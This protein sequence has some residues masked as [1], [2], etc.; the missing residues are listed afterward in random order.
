[1]RPSQEQI[2]QQL[3][4]E[5]DFKSQERADTRF[6]PEMYR[7]HSFSPPTTASTSRHES[8]R[9]DSLPPSIRGST[10]FSRR[11]R[12]TQEQKYQEV[13]QFKH[14]NDV[15]SKE[16]ADTRFKSEMYRNHSFPP[17][18][19]ASTSRNDSF[20]RSA[21]TEVYR[22]DSFP[23]SIRSSTPFRRRTRTM[24][25]HYQKQE[26]TERVNMIESWR[27]LRPQLIQ[28]EIDEMIL[29]GIS[30]EGGRNSL[31]EDTTVETNSIIVME[32][33]DH[34][35]QNSTEVMES[36]NQL[37][38]NP[39]GLIE[40]VDLIP[41]HIASTWENERN[42]NKFASLDRIMDNYNYIEDD[43]KSSIVRRNLSEEDFNHNSINHRHEIEVHQ[44]DGEFDDRPKNH[45]MMFAKEYSEPHDDII[46]EYQGQL[47]HKEGYINPHGIHE[48]HK[49]PYVTDSVGLDN[50]Q[51][52][53]TG[54]ERNLLLDD[55][56]L[57]MDPASTYT[58]NYGLQGAKRQYEAKNNSFEGITMEENRKYQSAYSQQ[59]GHMEYAGGMN[60]I[61]D[62][63]NLSDMNFPST[64]NERQQYEQQYN[65]LN[66]EQNY[67][68]Q[69]EEG[70]KYHPPNDNERVIA[71]SQQ[72]NKSK[73][74]Y[75]VDPVSQQ[76]VHKGLEYLPHNA[77][78]K[79]VASP[80]Q[81]NVHEF[82]YQTFLPLKEVT[83]PEYGI[84]PSKV[85][86]THLPQND[87]EKAVGS[88]YQN[89]IHKFNYQ[90]ALRLK[91]V[92][93]PDTHTGANQLTTMSKNPKPGPLF[94]LV[95]IIKEKI[96][97]PKGEVGSDKIK[98]ENDATVDDI[99]QHPKHA[100]LSN[101]VDVVKDKPCALEKERGSVRNIHVHNSQTTDLHIHQNDG[102]KKKTPMKKKKKTLMKKKKATHPNAT[103]I[104]TYSSTEESFEKTTSCTTE[105]SLTYYSSNASIT[106]YSTEKESSRSESESTFS[107][108]SESE[109]TTSS[110]SESESTSSSR[111]E[112]E[113]TFT[114]RSETESTSSSKSETESI[115]F[116]E[117]RSHH[118][119][120]RD[121]RSEKGHKRR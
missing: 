109:S 1:M 63:R 119:K 6:K 92:A 47:A 21:T 98:N 2:N 96:F 106:Y 102:Q 67:A 55:Q 14:E 89:N 16:R 83:R 27:S 66:N 28:N 59:G 50:E 48:Y 105:N 80:P 104:S 74:E 45:H 68:Q 79:A 62:T 90:T 43:S 87:P 81:K 97:A 61:R 15:I 25:S 36:R 44:S 76:F 10:P 7:N 32:S 120:H 84:I 46:S 112:S 23:R 11:L 5:N 53:Y 3:K 72:D 111:F 117:S 82:N 78:E 13:K 113:G 58:N 91:E 12:P 57:G 73:F 26:D 64:H 39:T 35:S 24:P 40:S 30:S 9:N 49:N 37:L 88:P 86:H 103:R 108:K 60:S 95:D 34:I 51:R 8:Y 33:M 85:I 18:P 121:T 31:Q 114:S 77:P 38:P 71:F 107:S 22:N 4:L 29:D 42:S 99:H 110:R 20:P 56:E 54:V 100:P 116:S 41:P 75:M 65:Q 19:T 52:T 17:P 94:N 118:R 101:I 69:T 70:L 115:S 93:R